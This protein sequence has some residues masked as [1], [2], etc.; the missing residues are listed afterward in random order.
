MHFQVQKLIPSLQQILKEGV[1]RD[2]Y[3]L[4]N[5]QRL[6]N[7]MREANVTLR[8]LMLHTAPLSHSAELNK[9][10]KA[11]RE[12]VSTDSAFNPETVFRLLLYTAQFELKLKEVCCVVVV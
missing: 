8:W 1:L 5:I 9:R 11:L 2:E 10:C 6:M 7:M 3:V 4:D 12:Q